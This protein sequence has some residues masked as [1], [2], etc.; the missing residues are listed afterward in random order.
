MHKVVGVSVG[1]L[2]LVSISFSNAASRL[3]WVLAR[4]YVEPWPL[5]Q[6]ATWPEATH[7]N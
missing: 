2:P 7:R 1:T 3:K 4:P 6:H 5:Q